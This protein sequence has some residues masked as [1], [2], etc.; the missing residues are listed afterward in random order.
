MHLSGV[1]VDARALNNHLRFLQMN[2]PLIGEDGSAIPGG[3]YTPASGPHAANI[4][5]QHPQHQSAL[6]FKR[7]HKLRILYYGTLGNS[8]NLK[9]KTNNLIFASLASEEVNCLGS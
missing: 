3:L 5:L 8:R 2:S 4:Q 7:V 9:M 1:I 6:D